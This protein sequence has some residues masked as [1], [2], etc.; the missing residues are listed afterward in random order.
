MRRLTLWIVSTV[1]SLALLISY[2]VSL[3]NAPDEGHHNPGDCP[4]AAAVV[5]EGS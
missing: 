3:G 1:A 4:L 2:Q 5:P